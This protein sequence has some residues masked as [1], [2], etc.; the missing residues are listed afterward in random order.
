M[1]NTKL[2]QDPLYITSLKSPTYMSGYSGP[3]MAVA[4][5]HFPLV[6]L[7][8]R[9]SIFIVVIVLIAFFVLSGISPRWALEK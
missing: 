8:F 3:S 2:Y 5:L 6:L 9:R 1:Y 7:L 4:S